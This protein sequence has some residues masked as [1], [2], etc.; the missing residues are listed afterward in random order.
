M[1]SIDKTSAPIGHYH[2]NCC[3]SNAANG[4]TD[5]FCRAVFDHPSGIS[6]ARDG[7]DH[8]IAPCLVL[9]LFPIALAAQAVATSDAG[10]AA[11]APVKA[12]RYELICAPTITL[13]PAVLRTHVAGGPVV[14][15]LPAGVPHHLPGTTSAELIISVAATTI[16]QRDE[17][18]TGSGQ[19]C[20]I[21]HVNSHAVSGGNIDRRGSASS[22]RRI[23]RLEWSSVTHSS[24]CATMR[25][26]SR[27]PLTIDVRSRS[28]R[29][30]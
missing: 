8:G 23:V 28:S 15:S 19:K 9:M 3:A 7:C 25:S 30:G 1:R 29:S 6:A 18:E 2:S 20:F 14:Q 10:A 16:G 12:A 17:C 27:R 26:D 21:R 22:A 11:A 5:A 4:L 13:M 24:I